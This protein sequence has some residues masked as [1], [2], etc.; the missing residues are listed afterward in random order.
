MASIDD[1]VNQRWEDAKE[2]LR[3]FD[4][5]FV[6]KLE[7]EVKLEALGLEAPW[8]SVVDNVPLQRLSSEWHLLLEACLELNMQ[9]SNIQVAASSMT[10]QA[11]EGVSDYEAGRHNNYHLRSWFIHVAAL[12]ERTED[13]VKKST[14]VYLPKYEKRAEI[15]K[16]HL[17]EVYEQIKKRVAQQRN[18]YVHPRRSW[19]SGITEDQLWEKLV[20]GG[21]SPSKLL[22]EFHFPPQG[23]YVKQGKYNHFVGETTMI[24]DCVGA[25]IQG[26]ETD[27][28]SQTELS[29]G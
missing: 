15:A 22:E 7:S 2:A 21:M 3:N 18:E 16:R 29:K 24:L 5:E 17:T 8:T 1:F 11:N 12:A 19:G 10:Y 23:I 14:E 26:L 28:M 27:M 9:A 4:G 20:S 6:R 13:V 25:I